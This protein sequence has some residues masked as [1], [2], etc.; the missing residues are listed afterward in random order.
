M[1]VQEKERILEIIKSYAPLEIA[2]EPKLS[3]EEEEQRFIDN[4]R[5][6]ITW[7][8]DAL[9]ERNQHEILKELVKSFK[10]NKVE[11]L[12]KLSNTIHL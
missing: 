10:G 1:T 6:D 11:L 7:Q 12:R 8:F 4:C 5:F 9:N 2:K 3:E